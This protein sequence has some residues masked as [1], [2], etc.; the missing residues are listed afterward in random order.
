MR[1]NTSAFSEIV[2]LPAN[3]S[4]YIDSN[5]NP[6]TIYIY[7]VYAFNTSG[8]SSYS[9]TVNYTAPAFV[10][11]TANNI[12]KYTDRSLLIT[13][14]ILNSGNKPFNN[15]QNPYS[16]TGFIWNTKPI[17]EDANIFVNNKDGAELGNPKGFGNNP[18]SVIRF[19][20]S[21]LSPSTKYYFRLYYYN[22]GTNQQVGFS[23]EIVITTKPAPAIPV[24]QSYQGGF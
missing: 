7:R 19:Y 13:G 5:L 11:I 2:S 23:N 1:I 15:P 16:M 3:S 10:L 22:G 4:S 8:N 24:G 9:S 21:N 12:V 17:V 14:K 20:V 18:D 6:S